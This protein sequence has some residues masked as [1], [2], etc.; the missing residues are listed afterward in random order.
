M[1]VIL[2]FFLLAIKSVGLA[3]SGETL[4]IEIDKDLL[5]NSHGPL[6]VKKIDLALRSSEEVE[7]KL[8]YLYIYGVLDSTEGTQWCNNPTEPISPGGIK[9]LASYA[10]RKSLK[11][12][13]D[14][15]A[16]SVIIEQFKKTSP[17]KDS[18]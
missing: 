8:A 14:A 1:R 12:N 10:L 4:P 13:P 2:G 3:D 11:E 7:Q 15:R 16:A 6:S 5:W 18:K 9:E 17:C